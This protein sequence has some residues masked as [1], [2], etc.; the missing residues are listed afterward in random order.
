M[1]A[2]RIRARVGERS[3]KTTAGSAQPGII[4]HTIWPDQKAYRWGEDGLAGICDRYQFDRFALAFWNGQDPILKNGSTGW[5][6]ARP[7]NGEDVKEY[8]FYLDSTP[9]H[10]YMKYLY[11][12]PQAQFPYSKLIEEKRQAARPGQRGYDCWIPRI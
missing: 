1:G 12:Y 9:S 4:S 8:Y 7:I 3:A 10:S 6:P 2:L 5:F 11:K